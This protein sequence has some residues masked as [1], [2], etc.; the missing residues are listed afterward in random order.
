MAALTNSGQ[1]AACAPN[2]GGIAPGLWRKT[3]V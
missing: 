2:Y 1:G 3:L